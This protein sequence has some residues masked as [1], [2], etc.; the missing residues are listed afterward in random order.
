V[1]NARI[2]ARC[3]EMFRAGLPDEVAALV[4]SGYNAS[5]PG[6]KAIGYR[7]FFDADGVFRPENLPAI[8]AQVALDSRHYAKRQET[9]FKKIPNIVHIDADAPDVPAQVQQLI[10]SFYPLDEMGSF[11]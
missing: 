11:L 9:W 6:M 1:V 4:R 3:R 10:R 5:C 2:D 7:E 8:E